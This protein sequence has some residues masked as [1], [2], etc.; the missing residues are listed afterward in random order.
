MFSATPPAHPWS[1]DP[2]VWGG[3]AVVGVIAALDAVARVQ[4]TGG[5]AVGAIVAAMLTDA[6]RTAGGRNADGSSGG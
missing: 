2:G 6:R 5:Y 3:A 4:L 1:R